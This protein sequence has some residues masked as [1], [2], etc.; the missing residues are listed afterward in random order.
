MTAPEPAPVLPPDLAPSTPEPAR[1][2]GPVRDRALLPDVLRG[3]ALLG[4]LIVNM[5]DFAGFLEW[6]QVGVDRAAQVV[7]DVLANGRFISIFAMLFGWGAAGI[8]ARRGA[9]VF[10]RRHAALLAVGALHYALVWHGDIISNYATLALALLLVAHLS[11]R[12]LLVMSGALGAWWLGLGLLGAVVTTGDQVRFVFLPDVLSTYAANVQTRA[13]EF[14]PLLWEGNLFN[15]PWLVALFCLGA[16]ARKSGLL[17]RPDEHRPLLRRL[18]VGGLGMGLPLGALLAYL[19]TRSDYAAG[20]LAFPVR[21]GGGLAGALGYVGVLGLLAAAGRLGA[22]RLFAASG[23]M[24]LTNYLMQSVVMT[25]IFYP[26]GLGLG[27]WPGTGGGWGAAAGLGVSLL[28]GLAQLP[29]S[30][31]WLSRFGRGPVESLVR[32]VAYGSA[33][34]QNRGHD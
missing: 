18:A 17:T 31:W 12:A 4:I 28:V 33:A 14:W 1:E 16:A 25:L 32:W 11:V 21:M 9:G 26:Y 29:L 20:A 13:A 5:Q 30:A 24:A 7:T 27:N 8:L 6:Q 10:L 15:G 22:W 3:V 19:N 34:R 23:R 2:T